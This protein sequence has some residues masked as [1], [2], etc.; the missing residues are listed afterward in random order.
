MKTLPLRDFQREGAKVLGAV[1]SAGEPSLLEGRD[2]AFV[3]LPVTPE[4][5]ARVLDFAE[6]LAAVMA[7]RQDQ[8]RAVEA[9]LDQLGLGEV[10]AEVRAMRK[11]LRHRKHSS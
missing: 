7:L 4:N 6:G 10:E 3:L 5:R 9:G 8:L 11:R 2:Q 1:P